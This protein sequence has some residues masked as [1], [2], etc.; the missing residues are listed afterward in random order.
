[1][2]KR[3]ASASIRR[4]PP[5]P[6]LLGTLTALCSGEEND[7]ALRL[8]SRHSPASSVVSDEDTPLVSDSFCGTE[9]KYSASLLS[10]MLQS[11]RSERAAL[12]VGG[13]VVGAQHLLPLL[14]PLRPSTALWERGRSVQRVRGGGK[15]CIS[16]PAEHPGR[17]RGAPH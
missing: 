11:G 2:G 9:C 14:S 3:I 4:I 13:D 7:L 15:P 5:A 10:R 12:T 17:M 8:G 16:V 1:M 6:Q